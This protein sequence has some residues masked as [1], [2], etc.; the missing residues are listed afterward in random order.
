M[1]VAVIEDRP[2]LENIDEI[3]VT[4]WAARCHLRGHQRPGFFAPANAATSSRLLFVQRYSASA[5]WHGA[6]G[7]D[8]EDLP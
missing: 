5:M 3:L 4:R 6:T 7:N 8:S 1:V 2:G